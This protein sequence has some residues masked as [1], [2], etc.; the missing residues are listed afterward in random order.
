MKN[1]HPL[2]APYHVYVLDDHRFIGEL[3]VNR[4]GTDKDMRVVGVGTTRQGVVD[5]I[6]ARRIDIVLLDMELEDGDGVEVATELLTLQPGLRIIGLS[7]FAETHYPLALLECGGRG[8]MSKRVST[9]DLLNGVRRVARGDLAISPDVAM[10]LATATREPGPV[11]QLRALTGKETEV[12]RLLSCGYS[13]EEISEHL[14][15][16]AKTVQ[17]HRTS[18]KRKLNAQTDVELCLMALRAGVVSMR[19]TK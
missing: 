10:H 4:L 13:V 12:L 2:S 5:C 1:H 7:A 3:L 6:A 18:M 19:Q 15:I 8:F 17:S 11:Y 16:S 14:A 9:T